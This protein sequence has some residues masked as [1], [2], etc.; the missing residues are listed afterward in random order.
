MGGRAIKSKDIFKE[1]SEFLIGIRF[2]KTHEL[3]AMHAPG[4]KITL[5]LLTHSIFD[6]VSFS[7]SRFQFNRE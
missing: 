2:C 1:T 5:F 7:A 6:V 3:L 4:M